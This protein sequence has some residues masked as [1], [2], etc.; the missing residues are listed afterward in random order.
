MLKD[1]E[2]I[3]RASRGPWGCAR[4]LYWIRGPRLALLGAFITFIALAVDPFTQ[5]IVT[6]RNCQTVSTNQTASMP[7]A[8]DYNLSVGEQIDEN[9]GQFTLWGQFRYGLDASIKASVYSGLFGSATTVINASTIHASCPGI[10]CTFPRYTTLGV[11]HQCAD[12][13]SHI[14]HV[15]DQNSP[16]ESNVFQPPCKWSLPTG[17]MLQSYADANTYFKVDNDTLQTFSMD[18]MIA[19]SSLSTLQLPNIPGTFTNVTFLANATSNPNCSIVNSGSAG[20]CVDGNTGA[21]NNTIDFRTFAVECSLFP[22]ARTYTASVVNGAV[23]EVEVK[24]SFG[25]GG[26]SDWME[27][28]WEGPAPSQ[29]NIDP[30]ENCAATWADGEK[31]EACTYE[32]GG[33]FIMA[34]GNF[35]W[36]FWNGSISGFRWTQAVSS[37]DALNIIYDEGITNLSQI[38]NVLGGIADSMTSAVRLTGSVG[39]FQRSDGS[40]RQGFVTGTVFLAETCIAVRWGWIALPAAV[41]LLSL[42][43]LIL[44]LILSRAPGDRPAWK[45]SALPVLF[46]G[47]S[48]SEFASKSALLTAA[49]MEKEAEGMKV[50]LTDKRT[51]ILRLELSQNLDDEH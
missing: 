41:T 18:F 35:F 34:A 5:N 51:G 49:E 19:N 8:D 10:N 46:H 23:V 32:A 37:N 38:D 11:C 26:W 4:M 48:T 1:F 25:T 13:S 15:C 40:G 45:S 16:A 33:T 3:D 42:L 36:H 9:P 6:T 24:R 22:C 17:Q 28:T 2:R 47:L 12:I 21:L 7:T 29:V 44:T 50:K 27:E 31:G 43:L 30:K 20:E 39:D 14:Q